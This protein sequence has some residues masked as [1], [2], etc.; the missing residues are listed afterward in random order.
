MNTKH[1]RELFLLFVLAVIWSSSFMFIKVAV[2]TLTPLTLTFAR[3]ALAAL[4]LAAYSIYRGDRLPADRNTWIAACI[5]GLLGNVLPFTLIHWGEQYVDSGLTAILMGVMPVAVALMAH[6]ATDSDPLT[7]R[8]AL[9]IAIGFAGLVV[10]VGLEA[11]DGFGAAI[12][13]QAAIMSAALSYSVTTI[14]V[15]RVASLTG[16][17]MAVA[18]VIC[19][20]LIMLPLAFTLERP[21]SLSPDWRSIGSLIMLGV[22]STGIATLLYFRLITTLGA[23]TFA[24]INYLIPIMGVGWGALILKE[25]VGIREAVAL[26]LIL[27]GV[28][29]VNRAR[30]D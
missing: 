13:A 21:L 20:A 22:F 7:G 23:T 19:G 30:R 18:T 3:I 2:D 26:A 24:Q 6:F 12:V 8:R 27:A 17:P 29:L 28:A 11:V 14:F 1:A 9:G 15:R 16:R 5:V 4:V 25:Q 10:L